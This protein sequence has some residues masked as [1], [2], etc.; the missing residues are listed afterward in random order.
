MALLG[1]FAGIR[2][3]RFV[4]RIIVLVV[5]AAVVYVGVTAAQVWLTGRHYDPHPA[6]AIVVMG[7]AQYDGSPSPDLRARLDE[8]LLLWRQHLAPLIA[9]TG[10]KQPGDQYTEAQAGATY[11]E[12]HGVPAADVLEAG[13]RDSWSNLADAAPLLTARHATDV[14]LVTDPFHE[15]RSLAIATDVGLHASP[16]P[17]QTSPIRGWSV[18]PYYAKEAVGVA[19][20]RIIGFDHLTAIRRDLG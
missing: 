4:L 9:V 12:L 15:D 17:T 19:L 11:L 8:A 20:G 3:L 10:S 13:G 14:L 7:A 6:Q 18:V 16:T 5:M 2:L 1:L